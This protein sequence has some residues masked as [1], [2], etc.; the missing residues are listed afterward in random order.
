MT[1][2]WTPGG[3]KAFPVIVIA[4]DDVTED[5]IPHTVEKVSIWALPRFRLS[6]QLQVWAELV[7][8]TDDE[9]AINGLLAGEATRVL[10]RHRIVASD[11]FDG[12]ARF[13]TCYMFAK[14][15]A[16]VR[17]AGVG[18]VLPCRSAAISARARVV[19]VL[20]DKVPSFKL[21]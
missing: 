7:L 10:W 8:E 2:T 19:E 17:H 18:R 5:T 12:G 13:Q 3:G 14:Y 16:S 9:E 21:N 15:L 4:W 11:V 6:P 1:T 20:A